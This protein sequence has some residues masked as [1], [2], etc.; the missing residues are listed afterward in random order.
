MQALE[1]AFR[2]VDDAVVKVR[3]EERRGEEGRGRPATRSV[4]S[5]CQ[6]SRSSI[7]SCTARRLS[8]DHRL[9]HPYQNP[10]IPKKVRHWAYMGSTAVVVV[11]HSDE[12]PAARA[13]NGGKARMS[14][15]SANVGDS[16]AVLSRRGKAVDLTEVR[17]WFT[18]SL[19]P[20]FL[21]SVIQI[22]KYTV[23]QLY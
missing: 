17:G 19:L 4:C 14:I 10:K 12:T 1:Q 11:L 6:V 20:S 8:H 21:L 7:H 9:I 18:A 5:A 2:V 3:R 15:I 16:R 22:N 23:N 13:A